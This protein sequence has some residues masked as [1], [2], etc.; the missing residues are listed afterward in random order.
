MN[1]GSHTS[2]FSPLWNGFPFPDPLIFARIQG[3]DRRNRYLANWLIIRHHWIQVVRQGCVRSPSAKTWREILN[4]LPQFIA[5]K[6]H[7]SPAY[8]SYRQIDWLLPLAFV[9]NVKS[10]SSASTKA[11]RAT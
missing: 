8:A 3:R 2:N 11:V 5:D 6:D 10:D 1:R 4:G 7:A 9:D